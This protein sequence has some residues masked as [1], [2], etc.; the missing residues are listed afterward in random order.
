MLV[1]MPCDSILYSSDNWNRRSLKNPY[2][3]IVQHSECPEAIYRVQTSNSLV[4]IS[5]YT[6]YTRKKWILG[7]RR[8]K[9]TPWPKG[10]RLFWM[11]YSKSE[12][13]SVES[14]LIDI[15]IDIFNING[16]I[17]VHYYFKSRALSIIYLIMGGRL[18]KTPNSNRIAKSSILPY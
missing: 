15:L 18:N 10:G 6:N 13:P 5:M 4:G 17:R 12:Y 9:T 14:R 3:D 16:V 1:G 8:R 11:M 2:R 7:L